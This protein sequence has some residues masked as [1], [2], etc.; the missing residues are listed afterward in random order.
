MFQTTIALT[1]E[2]PLPPSTDPE[3]VVRILHDHGA[4]VGLS[5]LV[6]SHKLVS[7]SGDTPSLSGTPDTPDTV[8]K[9]QTLA[10]SS[11]YEVTESVPLLPGG[12]WQTNTAF[13]AEFTDLPDGLRAV[14][15]APMGVEMVDIWSVGGGEGDPSGDGN[16]IMRLKEE[17]ELRC[18]VFL[19]PFVKLTMR[20]AHEVIHQRLVERAGG[21]SGSHSMK[22]TNEEGTTD[23]SVTQRDR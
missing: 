23:A 3:S 15:H 12:L 17:V 8:T 18:S 2:T 4:V 20:G 9:D 21:G 11:T 19:M 10:R 16:G 5:P 7:S 14:V 6:T 13:K 22:I 1:I